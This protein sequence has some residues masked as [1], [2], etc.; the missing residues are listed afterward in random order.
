MSDL[1]KE[2]AA[3]LKGSGL[4]W[5]QRSALIVAS[6]VVGLVLGAIIISAGGIVYTKAMS[7][8]EI[9]DKLGEE[10]ETLR[11]EL[12]KSQKAAEAERVTILDNLANL[13][14]EHKKLRDLVMKSHGEE[15]NDLSGTPYL[16]APNPEQQTTT[17]NLEPSASEVRAQR[18]ELM[19]QIDKEVYRANNLRGQ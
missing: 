7:T 2:V 11:E 3:E 9:R 12:Q 4:N 1:A 10:A 17:Q 15:K 6:N 8:D 13:A 16:P 19:Q 14:A 5:W 18:D